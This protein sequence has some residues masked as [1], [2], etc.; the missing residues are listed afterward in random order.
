M[1]IL[2]KCWGRAGADGACQHLATS[3]PSTSAVIFHL[4][5]RL[6]FRLA[7]GFGIAA[8]AAHRFLFGSQSSA[9]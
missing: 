1:K 5:L 8:H 2:S 3:A 9:P 7:L 4:R 6:H